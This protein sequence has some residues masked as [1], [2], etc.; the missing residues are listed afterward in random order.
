M[1]LSFRYATTRAYPSP[2]SSIGGTNDVTIEYGK[3]N[4][5][6]ARVAFTRKM[7]TNDNTRDVPLTSQTRLLYAR[8]QLSNNDI[9]KHTFKSVSNSFKFQCCK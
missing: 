1:F 3:M 9:T 8:G 2:D 7:E 6:H 4:S 5:G